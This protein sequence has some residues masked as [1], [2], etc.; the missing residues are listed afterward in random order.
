[1]S[2]A[3]SKH[4]IYSSSLTILIRTLPST[5]FADTLVRSFTMKSGLAPE[6]II[7]CWVCEVQTA[8]TRDPAAC[9]ALSPTACQ[10][11]QSNFAQKERT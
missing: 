1:M 3:G 10:L 6:S 7:A 4:L 8:S 2:V 9:P 11:L 5:H